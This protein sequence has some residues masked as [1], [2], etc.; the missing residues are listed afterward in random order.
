MTIIF[1]SIVIGAGQSG[2]AT[3]YYL[4]NKG[5]KYLVLEKSNQTAGSWPLYYDSLKLFSPVQYSSLP[6]LRFLG[7]IDLYPTK[8]EVM[9]YLNTYAQKFELNI[10][11]G[12]TVTEVLKTKELFLIKTEEGELFKAK[13]IIS[14]TGSFDSPDVPNIMD[15]ETFHGEIIHSSQYLNPE[16]YVNK[17][18]IVVGAGNSAVQI[19]YELREKSQ[20]TL[21]TREP[22]KFIPQRILGKDIHYWFSATGLDYFP[23]ANKL[24]FNTSVIDRNI[25]KRAIM[26]NNP[27]RRDM[28]VSI[29]KYGVTWESDEEEKVDTIIFATGYQPNVNYLYPL[30]GALDEK[31]IPVHQEG[32]ST[33]NKGLFYVGLPGQRSFSS[34]T[35]RGVGK[36][37]KYIVNKV[38]A[39][40]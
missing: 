5:L 19:A 30:Q 26:N 28:F 23:F 27:D 18:V 33:S 12:K 3:A 9:S 14:A 34:A 2:L 32:A 6:G 4:K 24:A 21:A 16:P 22:I 15:I 10:S 8:I 7:D 39:L 25:F 29:N 11:T 13:T 38:K 17:R 40:L 37:A 20:V 1:D 31:G 36:D 35:L